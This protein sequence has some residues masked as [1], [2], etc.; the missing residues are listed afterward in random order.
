MVVPNM[1]KCLKI[2]KEDSRLLLQKLPGFT[3]HLEYMRA[4]QY[5]QTRDR[6][7][8]FENCQKSLHSN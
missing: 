1:V 8:V 5:T 4:K 3:I 2:T 6:R 7:T